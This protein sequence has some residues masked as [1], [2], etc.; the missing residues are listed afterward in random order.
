MTLLVQ[1]IFIKYCFNDRVVLSHTYN[2]GQQIKKKNCICDEY[3]IKLFASMKLE[4]GHNNYLALVLKLCY[5][6]DIY[7]IG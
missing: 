3:V 2:T 1:S 7:E 6:Y 5:H 4:K